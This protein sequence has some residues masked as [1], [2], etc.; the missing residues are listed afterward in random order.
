MIRIDLLLM[1]ICLTAPNA[2]FDNRSHSIL[3]KSK[4]FE[5]SF[6]LKDE[7]HINQTSKIITKAG[8]GTR[9]WLEGCMLIYSKFLTSLTIHDGLE[10]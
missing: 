6:F 7:E 2:L 8:Q 9:A 5:N 1:L 4:I 10:I 3:P